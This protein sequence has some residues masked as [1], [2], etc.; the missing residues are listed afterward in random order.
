MW[1]INLGCSISNS[2]FP[3]III[4]KYPSRVPKPSDKHNAYKTHTFFQQ[5]S[6]ISLTIFPLLQYSG[7]K[8]NS[9][10]VYE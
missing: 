4:Q 2:F 3:N 8:K 9:G 7:E 5:S 6:Q 10:R 1:M